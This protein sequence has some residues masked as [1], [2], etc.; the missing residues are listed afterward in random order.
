LSLD[1]N[2]P[3][4]QATL[5]DELRAGTL[6]ERRYPQLEVIGIKKDEA[7]AVD[8]MIRNHSRNQEI[9]AC[10][11]TKCRYDCTLQTFIGRY[12]C[13]WLVTFDKIRKGM[14]VAE[15]LCIPLLGFLYIPSDD[16]LLWKV[17]F[18]PKLGLMVPIK[19]DRTTT[20]K[21]INGGEIERANAYIDMDGA[22]QI[23]GV[24]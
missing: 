12:G 9:T 19:V 4:G 23:N 7:S 16:V 6:F 22:E 1:I 21:T 13:R 20:Q 17:I 8:A 24:V 11:E 15:L 2:T 18:D 14:D 3:K 10:V 5:K